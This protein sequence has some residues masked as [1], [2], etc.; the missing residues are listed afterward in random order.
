MKKVAMCFWC[1]KEFLKKKMLRC[2]G[3]FRD[4]YCSK[5]CRIEAWPKH[6]AACVFRYGDSG[7]TDG[8]GSDGGDADADA[9]ADDGDC[10]G[11]TSAQPYGGSDGIAPNIGT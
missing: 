5:E 7:D 2:L 10:D 9:D 4:Q 8:G 1:Q 6:K 3:C 11:G